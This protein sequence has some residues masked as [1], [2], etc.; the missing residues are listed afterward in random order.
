MAFTEGGER[1][2]LKETDDE[3]KAVMERVKE[4]LKKAYTAYHDGS[5]RPLPYEQ[6]EVFMRACVACAVWTQDRGMQQLHKETT[7]EYADRR[8]RQA[9]KEAR[10]AA[11]GKSLEELLRELREL[12]SKYET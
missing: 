10:A 9:R 2:V 5:S 8:L 4:G 12:L 11:R 3:Y 7:E 6:Y 1:G